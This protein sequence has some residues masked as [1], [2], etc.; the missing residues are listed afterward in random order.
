MEQ[1][2]EIGADALTGEVR[3]D[4]RKALTPERNPDVLYVS[5]LGC[6]FERSLDD[7]FVH[8][9]RL[10]RTG[11]ELARCPASGRNGSK[12]DMDVP[13]VS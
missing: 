10:P 1:L 8:L 6:E 11:Q 4:I 7:A 9:Y 12:P 2:A 13:P 5:R 3:I